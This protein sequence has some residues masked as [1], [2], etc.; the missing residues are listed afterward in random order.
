MPWIFSKG[1]SPFRIMGLVQVLVLRTCQWLRT[2]LRHGFIHGCGCFFCFFFL[3]TLVFPY[4]HCPQEVIKVSF[5]LLPGN[6]RLSAYTAALGYFM[7]IFMLYFCCH[8]LDISYRSFSTGLGSTWVLWHLLK[9]LEHRRTRIAHTITD[10]VLHTQLQHK[11]TGS[12]L[13]ERR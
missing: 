3:N 9:S 13:F 11:I 4:Q 1:G 10:S 12:S 8:L 5:S 7:R 2:S 6:T